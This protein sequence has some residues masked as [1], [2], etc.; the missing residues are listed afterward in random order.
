M[1]DQDDP[2]AAVLGLERAVIVFESDGS[3]GDDASAGSV[4]A[5]IFDLCPGPNDGVDADFDQIPD[6]CDP[7]QGD[8]QTGDSDADGVCDDL[9]ACLGDD[10]TGDGDSDDLCAD[11]DCDD[12]DPLNACAIFADDFETGDTSS[13]SRQSP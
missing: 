5:R 8:N 13:W 3:P 10:A 9:D 6:D 4:Q 11:R 1:D 2:V 7:C 12:G